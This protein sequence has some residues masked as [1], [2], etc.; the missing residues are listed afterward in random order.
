M[1]KLPIPINISSSIVHPWRIQ[2]CRR[3]SFPDGN[4][5][6][7]G[8]VNRRSVL[9]ICIL[10]NVNRALIGTNSYVRPNVYSGT[11]M[12]RR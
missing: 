7:P 11:E 9:D 2:L 6:S 3:H 1:I 8:H 4:I 10:T 5:E 12:Y